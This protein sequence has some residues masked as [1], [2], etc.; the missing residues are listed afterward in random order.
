[1]EF[2]PEAPFD[3][4]V[5]FRNHP[6]WL[7]KCVDSILAQKAPVRSV[8][9]YD[10]DSEEDYSL[11]FAGGIVRY[12]RKPQRTGQ[13]ESLKQHHDFMSEHNRALRPILP[14]RGRR[15]QPRIPL[16]IPSAP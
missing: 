14:A 8:T 13:L 16:S 1:M 12:V 10:D 6:E 11:Q 5:P 7:H 9:L 4:V 3:V 2:D 15:V